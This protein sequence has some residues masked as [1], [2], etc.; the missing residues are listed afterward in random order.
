MTVLVKSVGV[1]ATY[2]ST[3]WDVGTVQA[4]SVVI[5]GV[6][7]VGSQAA[8]IP[9]PSGGTNVDAEARATIST[10]LSALRHHGLISA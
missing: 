6:Q 10:M 5:D 9:E 3:G 2:R 1:P 7:V 4:S 8:A